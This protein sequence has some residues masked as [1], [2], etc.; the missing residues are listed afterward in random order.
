MVNN[1]TPLKRKR[2]IDYINNYP[3]EVA[4]SSVHEI[5]EKLEIN[6]ATIVRASKDLGF[7]GFK[8]LKQEKQKLFKVAQN[9][10]DTVMRAMESEKI[11]DNIIKRSLLKDIEILN[12]TVANINLKTIET[13]ARLIHNSERTYIVGIDTG[14]TRMVA[15]LLGNELRTFHPGVLEILHGNE[16]LMDFI[17]HCT[18][19]D[20]I[21]CIGFRRS[22]NLTVNAIKIAKSNGATIIA[23]VDNNSSPLIQF[24]DHK[25]ITGIS[26]EFAYSSGVS[27]ISVCNALI[28]KFVKIR[29][30]KAVAQLKELQTIL[31]DMDLWHHS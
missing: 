6:P 20:V 16:F 4:I 28:N 2:A 11:G 29:G 10:Y 30:K 17:R 27:A 24:A 13:V 3:D 18:P 31:N 1:K 8:E 19:K 12:E 22:W 7:K 25:L 21:V 5:A 9:P 23:L 14:T 26:G 15:T